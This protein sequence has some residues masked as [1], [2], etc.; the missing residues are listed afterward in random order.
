[1]TDA[2]LPDKWLGDP[3]FDEWEPETWKFFI[4]CLMWSN[5]YG[6]DGRIPMVH[7]QKLAFGW[8]TDIMLAHLERAGVCAVYK[9]AIE[10]DWIGIGQSPAAEVEN[11]RLKNRQKQRDHRDRESVAKDDAQK[12]GFVTSDVTS[13]VSSDV[14]SDVGQDRLGQDDTF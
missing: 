14:S 13:D 10:L 7:L 5:R 6:T 11:R 3:K 1:M 9:H 8:D 12:S 4:D 2:R